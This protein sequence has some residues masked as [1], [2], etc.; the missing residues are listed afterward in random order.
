MVCLICTTRHESEKTRPNSF[1]IG[2]CL[3]NALSDQL[4]G[5]QSSHQSIRR[6][7][8]QYMRENRDDYTP[9]LDVLPGGAT[10]RNPKRK[11]AATFGSSS[12]FDM[13]TPE[14]IDRAFEDRLRRMGQGGT[15]GDNFE[16]VAFTRAYNS[17]VMV[18]QANER[19]YFAAPRTADHKQTCCIAYHVSHIIQTHPFTQSAN[20]VQTWEHYSS[21]RNVEG[22]HVGRPDLRLGEL[23]VEELSQM[24]TPT[25]GPIN[26]QQW[27]IDAVMRSY[28]LPLDESTV[29]RLLEECRGNT[30]NAVLKLM[31]EYDSPDRSSSV[32][33]ST[34]DPPSA[35]DED[36]TDGPNKKQDRRMSRNTKSESRSRHRYEREQY[37]E[38]LGSSSSLDHLEST[39]TPSIESSLQ[40]RRGRK[41]VL[42]DEDEIEDE[43]MADVSS[44]PALDDGSTSSESEYS[45]ST[46]PPKPPITLRLCLKPPQQAR[47]LQPSLSP[48]KSM[49]KV[50]GPKKRLD[51]ARDMKS[52]KKRAQKQHAKERR[53]AAVAK[54]KEEQR[55]QSTMSFNSDGSSQASVNTGFRLL[56]V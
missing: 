17:D 19:L 27:Q 14:D 8:V 32:P 37:A 45:A 6:T 47:T 28:W 24:R 52:V 7:V 12:D 20:I 26:V 35:V 22:P 50:T 33:S 36:F 10:R 1:G 40:R 13:P 29:I 3:F 49:H 43:E 53:Q 5:T 42:D 39:T 18:F 41:V 51:A 2:N 31:G 54:P 30:D 9:F 21:I 25:T 56:H 38:S 11:N 15:Y 46:S 44:L 4:Y 55:E 48:P 34:A 23:T 16:I